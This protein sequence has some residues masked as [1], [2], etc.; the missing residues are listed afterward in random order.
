MLVLRTNKGVW[1]AILWRGCI[2]ALNDFGH[3]IGLHQ[4]IRGS[5]A[6]ILFRSLDIPVL[7]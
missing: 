4:C 6:M 2:Q 7:A 5:S 3:I 1:Y